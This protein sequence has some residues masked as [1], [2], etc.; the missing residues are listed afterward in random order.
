MTGLLLPVRSHHPNKCG[1]CC[2]AADKGPFKAL[3]VYQLVL[4]SI[5]HTESKFF[6]WIR[7]LGL[8]GKIGVIHV[9]GEWAYIFNV[10]F[11]R[12][13]CCQV[14][15]NLRTNYIYLSMA[16]DCFVKSHT[17]KKCVIKKILAGQRGIHLLRHHAGGTG[18]RNTCFTG[19]GYI[20]KCWLK[21]NK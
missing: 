6:L 20:M 15:Q 14:S 2:S 18:K 19:L 10:S 12:N 3:L 9:L 17:N 16:G 7:A 21:I 8:R 13:A 4:T 1:N 5:E 11:G